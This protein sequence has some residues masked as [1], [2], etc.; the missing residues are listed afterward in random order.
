VRKKGK[1]NQRRNQ[2]EQGNQLVKLVH[3][4]GV[5]A[6]GIKQLVEFVQ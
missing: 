1:R 3:H 6:T 4:L 5:V 2:D